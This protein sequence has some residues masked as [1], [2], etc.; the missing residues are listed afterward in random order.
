MVFLVSNSVPTENLYTVDAHVPGG[1]ITNEA[2]PN[3]QYYAGKIGERRQVP[4]G[5]HALNLRNHGETILYN[6]EPER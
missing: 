6:K 4:S 5:M 2:L 1:V 3:D